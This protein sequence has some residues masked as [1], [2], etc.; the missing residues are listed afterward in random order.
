MYK[1]LEAE[2]FE[3]L[4]AATRTVFGEWL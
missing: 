4:R 1:R 3:S 2:E